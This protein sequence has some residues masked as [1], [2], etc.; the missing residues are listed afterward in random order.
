MKP[1]NPS[2]VT[3][4]EDT[5]IRTSMHVDEHGCATLTMRIED[6]NGIATTKVFDLVERGT[7]NAGSTQ[8]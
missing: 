2:T 5:I 4:H 7:C 3:A 1:T 8:R 6:T